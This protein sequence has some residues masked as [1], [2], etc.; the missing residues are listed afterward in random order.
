MHPVLSRAGE[1]DHAVIPS[2]DGWRQACR[3]CGE[4]GTPHTGQEDVKTERALGWLALALCVLV[5][6]TQ[7]PSA[8]ELASP[9]EHAER[10]ITQIPLPGSGY[11]Y[12]V[13]VAEGAVWV[14]SHAGLFRIDPVT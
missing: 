5:A 13:A 14:T 8:S 3:C 7:R 12:D 6:C 1:R 2:M 10:S 9:Q 11:I 4:L